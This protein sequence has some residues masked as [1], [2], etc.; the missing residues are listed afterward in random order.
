MDL[1]N[2]MGAHKGGSCL[3][4]HGYPGKATLKEEIS[5]LRLEELSRQRGHTVP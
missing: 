3:L 2:V 5:K 1:Y 4:R